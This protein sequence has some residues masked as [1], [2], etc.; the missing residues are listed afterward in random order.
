MN[1][2]L[3]ADLP[4]QFRHR[5]LNCERRPNRSLRVVVVRDRGTEHGHD[6]VTD[7]PLDAAPEHFYDAVD[8]FEEAGGKFVDNLGANLSGHLGVTSEIGE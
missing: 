6:A 3:A 7:M 1:P 8:P 5:F 4:T 2:E